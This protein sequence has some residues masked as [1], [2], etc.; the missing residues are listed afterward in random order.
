MASG[1]TQRNAVERLARETTEAIVDQK[2]IKPYHTEQVGELEWRVKLRD[3]NEVEYV[4]TFLV[5]EVEEEPTRGR[6]VE[7]AV[8]EE[9]VEDEAET[10]DAV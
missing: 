9:S 8:V 4:A 5:E 2:Q 1:N 6:V 7:E 10:G 3:P